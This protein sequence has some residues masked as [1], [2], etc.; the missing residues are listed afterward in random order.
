V[1]ASGGLPYPAVQTFGAVQAPETIPTV[2]GGYHRIVWVKPLLVMV[3][4]PIRPA[5]GQALVE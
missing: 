5:V 1:R 2:M 3:Q 4:L